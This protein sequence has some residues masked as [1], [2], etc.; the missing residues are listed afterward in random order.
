MCAARLWRGPAAVR[1]GFGAGS[2]FPSALASPPS[3]ECVRVT[4]RCHD[5]VPPPHP[6]HAPR[7]FPSHAA[8][9]ITPAVRSSGPSGA[10]FFVHIAMQAG[11]GAADGDAPVNSS[12]DVDDSG[13]AGERMDRTVAAEHQDRGDNQQQQQQQASLSPST[14]LG[15]CGRKRSN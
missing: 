5:R 11:P 15:E 4:C 12:A 8:A 2:V 14:V 1:C 9:L 7:V 13:G 6:S 3:H 10:G